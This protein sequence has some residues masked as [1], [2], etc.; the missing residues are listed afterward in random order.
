ML[1]T[2]AGM[3]RRVAAGIYSLTPLGLRAHRKTEV[4]VAEEM[5]RAG[6]AG[7]RAAHPPAARALGAERTLGALRRGRDPLPPEG[8]QGRRV[9]P[10]ADGRGGRDDARCVGRDLLPPASRDPLPDPHEVPR[11]DPPALRPDAR[12][13]VPDVR[14][15]LLRRGRR[16]ASTAPTARR[17]RAYRRIFER[18]GLDVHGRRGGLGRDRRRRSQEFMVLAGDGRGRRRA[19]RR[20]RL[21]REPREGGDRAAGRAPWDGRDGVD[22]RRRRNARARAASTTSST[23]SGSRP[24]ADDQVPRLR[25][26]AGVR[27]A[28]LL[29]GDL[30]ANE[31]ALKHALGVEHLALASEEKVEKA[32]GAPVGYVGPHRLPVERARRRGRVR[33]RAPSTPSRARAGATGTC[34]ASSH[35]PGRED[36]GGWA[37]FAQARRRPLPALRQAARHRP[38]HRGR[39]TSSSSARKY[40]SPRQCEF[41]DEKGE[42]RPVVMGTY[43]IGVGRTDGV[44]R[45]AAPR[46]GRD[47]LAAGA[48][49]L[50]DR[51]RV[52]ER[53]RRR[54]R[55]RG[56]RASTT[57]LVGAG[58]TS[59]TT[60]GTSGPESSSRTRTC[61]DSRSASTSA[62]AALKEGKVESRHAARQAVR[63]AVRRGPRR[64]GRLADRA[65][66]P[67]PGGRGRVRAAH[68]EDHAAKTPSNTTPAGRKGKIEVVPTKP[69]RTQE[70]LSLAYSP[71]VARAVPGRSRR[72]PMRSTT[73]RPRATSSRSI[74]NGTAVL[75]LGNIGP[76]A[77]KPVMEGK[78]VLFKRFADIDVFDIEV[79]AT[80]PTDVRRDRRRASR[81]PSAASTSRTSSRPSASRS[82]RRS[83]SAS[84]SPSSTTTS[85]APPS[86]RRRPCLNALEVVGKSI[87]E[88]QGRFRRARGVRRSPARSLYLSYGVKRRTC[89]WW[90][91]PA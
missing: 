21:R 33:P 51:A 83:G 15:V 52:P 61:S 47:R 24:T 32:T 49:A 42:T 4:I 3:M 36:V 11:R 55:E 19:L 75:G 66:V 16:R 23:S 17:T 64:G 31:V 74:S 12:A 57:T 54:R 53:R 20:V 29:R 40:S 43:G 28:R 10:R 56:R 58:S 85:T 18:C 89:G 50:R 60:T 88:R 46:R 63:R 67:S 80:D 39:A 41:T 2:R 59:S 87:G 79:D 37:L 7:G 1:L 91:S 81:R 25:D 73:T 77:G 14:R 84:R 5:D 38:R 70:D 72:T 27:R 69:C 22:A 68:E 76:L 34:G 6:C 8:P 48:G 86:S 45:R 90:T 9:L 13:R 65:R 44:R 26:R 82:R 35:R 30:D 78:G 62:G 71:G